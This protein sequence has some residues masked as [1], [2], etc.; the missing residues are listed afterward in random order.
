[1]LLSLSYCIVQYNIIVFNVSVIFAS[2]THANTN[3]AVGYL[4]NVI[5]SPPPVGGFTLILKSRQSAIVLLS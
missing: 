5:F 1:M 4:R 3:A 2:F